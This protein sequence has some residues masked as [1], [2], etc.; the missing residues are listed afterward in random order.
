MARKAFVLVQVLQDAV[1]F[2]W[3]EVGEGHKMGRLGRES[4]KF[5]ITEPELH[6]GP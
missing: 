5:S 6:G 2:S 4:Q 1:D 3:R